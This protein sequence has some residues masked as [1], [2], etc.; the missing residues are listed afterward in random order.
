MVRCMDAEE[1]DGEE[2]DNADGAQDAE[3]GTGLHQPHDKLFAAAFGVPENTAALLRAELPAELAA[4]IDWDTLKHEPGSFV[5]PGFRRAHTDLLFSAKARG[6]DTFLYVLFEHQSSR[7]PRLVLRLLH[8]MVG[9]WMRLESRF[10]WP[11]KLPPILPVVLSQN[12]VLW[13]M[14]ERL[15]ELLELPEDLEEPLRPYVP[16]FVCRHLQLAGMDYERIPGTSSG[17]FV[18]RT[19]KAERLGE[20][21]GDPVWDEALIAEVPARIFEMVVRYI[22]DGEIDRRA[23]E[24]RV[25][26]IE[27]Q[28]V[29]SQAMTLAQVYRQEGRQEDILEALELRFG[30]VPDG[31]AEAVRSVSDEAALRSLHRSA[32]QSVSLEV[33]SEAL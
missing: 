17:V 16:D 9:I 27:N 25:K 15:A 29:R 4:A 3:G 21:L 10:P 32:I 13:D 28:Q 20:L 30:A 33:F 7:D 31:L 26:R 18:L 23:F 8:Y 14:P 22:L 19:M 1:F 6:R 24:D 12:A 2:R 5:D 11:Q